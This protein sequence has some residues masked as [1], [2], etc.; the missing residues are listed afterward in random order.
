MMDFASPAGQAW[1]RYW[2]GIF[3]P[4]STLRGLLRDDVPPP[5]LPR[6]AIPVRPRRPALT[7]PQS[8]KPRP[9]RAE[10][11]IERDIARVTRL[12]VSDWAKSIVGDPR[13]EQITLADVLEG[14]EDYFRI[15][16]QMRRLNTDAYKYFSRVGAP[17][18]T[19]NGAIWDSQINALTIASPSLLPSYFGVFFAQG[20]DDFRQH[21]LTEDA[22]MYEFHL[23]EK[24]RNHGTVAPLGST[25]FTHNTISLHRK[26]WLTDD[27]RRGKPWT[28]HA[29]GFWWYLGVLP[30]GSIRALPH[31]MS[32]FQRLP[33]GDGVYH[34]AFHIPPGVRAMAKSTDTVH[35]FVRKWFNA[36]V[37]STAA[38][39]AGV[40]VTIRQ[41]K[42][43]ARVGVPVGNLRS[44]FADRDPAA[45]GVRRK[46]IMHLRLGHDRHMADGRIIPVGEHLSGERHFTW[47]GYQV[48]VGVPGIHFPSPEGFDAEIFVLNDPDAPLPDD[49]E[50]D[51]L[52]PI[53]EAAK[54]FQ[55]IIRRREQVPIRKGNPTRTYPGNSLPDGGG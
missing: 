40:T 33:G 43:A 26:F 55:S 32:H 1:L 11:R 41:G 34:S 52:V 24:P 28:R 45:E 54:E 44:F 12:P 8:T 49:V 25:I 4:D 20:R 10:R 47:R 30:D 13:N 22:S 3:G 14:V 6:P 15:F 5:R 2:V 38:A 18:L 19:S 36:A 39:I 29:W 27:E 17:I 50:P 48:T 42:R 21:V 16:D 51:K 23:F 7:R 53:S 31:R 35:D 46:A 9:D 37:A